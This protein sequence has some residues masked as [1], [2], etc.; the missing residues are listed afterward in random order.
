MP[1]THEDVL[2]S[3]PESLA[4]AAAEVQILMKAEAEFI[5]AL[6]AEKAA[7]LKK[8]KLLRQA[9]FSIRDFY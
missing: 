6:K 7:A 9:K 5:A 1:I 3:P 8:A 2:K 4:R